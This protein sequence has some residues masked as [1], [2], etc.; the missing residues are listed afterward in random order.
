[1]APLAVAQQG[2]GFSFARVLLAHPL[3][4]LVCFSN[5][6]I[7]SNDMLNNSEIF[8]AISIG[9]SHNLVSDSIME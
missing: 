7:C 2:G 9:S 5:F 6:K 8:C 3:F 4:I 1:M